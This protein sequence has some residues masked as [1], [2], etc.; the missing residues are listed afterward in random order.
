MLLLLLFPVK[1]VSD[2][3][4]KGLLKFEILPHG[5]IE[6]LIDDVSIMKR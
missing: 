1:I 5:L 2:Q 6:I 4:L 3:G